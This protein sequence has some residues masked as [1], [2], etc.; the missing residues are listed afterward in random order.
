[1]WIKR[2]LLDNRKIQKDSYLWNMIGSLLMAFQSVFML[3][4]LTRTVGLEEA[5]RFT[6]ANAN[7]NLFLTI[8][9]YGMC[10][11]QVFD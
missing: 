1:M 9:K 2:F 5:G 7:V 10:I 11:F 6:I 8:G 3:M 4:I